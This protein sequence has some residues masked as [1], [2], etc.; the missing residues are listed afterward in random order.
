MWA[1]QKNEIASSQS[2]L[3][4][5]LRLYK[6]NPFDLLTLRGQAGRLR[7]LALEAFE[8]YDLPV[9]DVRLVWMFTN[10]LFRV[11]TSGG[12]SYLLRVC[13][14]GWRT[15]EDPRSGRSSALPYPPLEHPDFTTLA[16][17]YHWSVFR[18]TKTSGFIIPSIPCIPVKR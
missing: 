11:F 3:A 10:T 1:A 4:M 5:T 8:Q 17:F 16:Y 14:P 7:R 13:A 12:T 18:L 2:L 9:T 6:M 15:G